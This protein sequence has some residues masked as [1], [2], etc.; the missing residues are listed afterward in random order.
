M[1]SGIGLLLLSMTNRLGRVVDRARILAKELRAAKDAD[2]RKI[3]RQIRVL[4]R[5]AGLLRNSIVAASL[6]ILLVAVI[7][8]GLFVDYLLA[9]NFQALI[10][11][12]FGAC[13]LALI[14]SMILFLQDLVLSLKALQTEVSD[15]V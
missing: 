12:T 15:Q 3:R 5:R 11:L 10:G 4:Y 7:I 2:K 1:I 6:S 9:A 14:V 13:I 8:L